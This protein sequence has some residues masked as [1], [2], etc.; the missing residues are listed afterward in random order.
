QDQQEEMS[1]G[2]KPLRQ[3]ATFNKWSYQLMLAAPDFPCGIQGTAAHLP[4]EAACTAYTKTTTTPMT[5]HS[6][7]R[8]GPQHRARPVFKLTALSGLLAL[9]AAPW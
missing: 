9:G 1:H 2:S 3:I 6:A 4:G 5:T 7:R 8:P